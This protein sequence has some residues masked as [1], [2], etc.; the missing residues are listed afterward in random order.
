MKTQVIKTDND[1]PDKKVIS[2]AAKII[3]KG[4]LVAFPT[5]TVYGLAADYLNKKALARLYKV[6]NRPADKPFTVHIS[7]YDVIGALFC[8]VSIFEEHLI[9]RF[10]PGPLTLILRNEAGGKIG[11]RMPKN[12]LALD[13]ISAC[14]TPI[15]APSANISGNSA[16]RT[17]GQVLRELDGKIDILLDCGETELGIESTVVDAS[18]F[19]YRILREGAVDKAQIADVGRKL[20]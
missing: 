15:A 17:A 18:S 11:F 19:P 12:R 6:K 9:Q 2:E 14:K 3:K 4:G 1:N 20:I 10:W 16:P 7:D 5:E 13:L 8:E